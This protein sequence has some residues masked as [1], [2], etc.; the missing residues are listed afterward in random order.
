MLFDYY[1]I[2]KIYGIQPDE[3]QKLVEEVQNEFPDDQMLAELH[4]VRAL[5]FY[6]E[7]EHDNNG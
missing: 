4:I 3:L 2:S 5:R 7:E 6:G 1:K